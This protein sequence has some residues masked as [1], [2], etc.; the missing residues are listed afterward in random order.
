MS[1]QIED[2]RGAVTRAGRH[3]SFL[4]HAAV[5]SRLSVAFQ[6]SW[7]KVRERAYRYAP[8]EAGPIG[9]NLYPTAA[10]MALGACAVGAFYDGE[11]NARL[12]LDPREEAL[13]YIISAG[14]RA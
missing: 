7:W 13:L 8:L 1:L 11:S 12:G 10:S 4:G 6:R 2:S 9:Q 5:C 3:H 14:D